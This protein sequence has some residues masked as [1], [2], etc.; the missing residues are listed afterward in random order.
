MADSFHIEMDDESLKRYAGSKHVGMPNERRDFMGLKVFMKTEKE[1]EF[2]ITTVLGFEDKDGNVLIWFA[3]GSKAYE[4]GAVVNL[5]ATI[6]GY[7]E[8]DRVRKTVITRAVETEEKK[9]W[10]ACTTGISHSINRRRPC[11]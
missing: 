2:G 6:K 11:K 5:R 4:K 7:D 10:K 8:S 1:G 9:I 3:T